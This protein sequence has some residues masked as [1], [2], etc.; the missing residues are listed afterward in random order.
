MLPDSFPLLSNTT[1]SSVNLDGQSPQASTQSF[2]MH[3]V[4][5]QAQAN[6]QHLLTLSN[7]LQ[8]QLQVLNPET[9]PKG[10]ELLL[11]VL[12]NPTE[13][14]QTT[15]SL[16]VLKITLPPSSQAQPSSTANQV[17]SQ[18]FIEQVLKPFLTARIA[19]LEQAP[20]APK[21][22]QST[23]TYQR[24]NPS[25]SPNLQTNHITNT[26]RAATL[27]P[28]LQANT[29]QSIP[30]AVQ[31]I[32]QQ[33]QQ[34]LP[35]TQQLEQPQTLKEHLHNN[36]LTYEKQL[37]PLLK[38][39]QAER[40]APNTI[41]K[42]LLQQRFGLAN[43][44]SNTLTTANQPQTTVKDSISQIL[45][46]VK[47]KLEQ[48][49]T[50][51][52][53]IS[54]D[55]VEATNQP[56]LQPLPSLLNTLLNSNPKAVLSRALTLWAQQ[57]AQPSNAQF[58]TSTPPPELNST[59]FRQLQSALAHIEH[60]Q[61]QWLQQQAQSNHQQWQLTIPLLFQHQQEPQEVR[62]TIN[63]DEQE[64]QTD[65]QQ[66]IIRWRLR[67]YFDL[68]ELGP[69]DVDLELQLPKLKA[70]FWSQQPHTLALLNHKMQPLRK[71]LVELGAEVEE[72]KVLHGQLPE[73]TRNHIQQHWVDVHG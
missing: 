4:N 15:T 2:V 72:I 38:A 16:E 68:P 6:G 25:A 3:V 29:Q 28:L 48:P 14:Q 71:Q 1:L 67:L 10:T 41:F 40:Q 36:A 9:L 61:G 53:S 59:V 17:P 22:N 31:E 58:Q 70:T 66:K 63:K 24:P 20:S 21:P 19:L 55:K 34:Q 5:S 12:K 39:M 35:A 56:Q 43:T 65:K 42:Q 73:P 54:A 32:L 8:Q 50:G 27:M 26:Q 57:L 52:T 44:A 13:T 62:L 11:A 64:G 51:S 18:N 30:Q 60:E 45:Q 69:L 23:E 7:H 47:N 49:F 33:W 37:L 46:A